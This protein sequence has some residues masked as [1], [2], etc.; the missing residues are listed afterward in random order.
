MFFKFKKLVSKN[1]L[2][3]L[4]LVS[5]VT[6]CNINSCIVHAEGIH[7]QQLANNL[8]DKLKVFIDLDIEIRNDY[9]SDMPQDDKETYFNVTKQIKQQLGEN[10]LDAAE[11]Y[12]VAPDGTLQVADSY[13][14]VDILGGRTINSAAV[15]CDSIGAGA[16]SVLR[17]GGFYYRLI[18]D[19]PD[20]Y[21]VDAINCLNIQLGVIEE[22]LERVQS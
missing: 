13:G 22:I 20:S 16:V 5:P 12:G 8:A 3:G 10:V 18:E 7:T 21:F 14:E 17:P 9:F 2:I 6:S 4:L 1:L 11:S 19:K 15:D